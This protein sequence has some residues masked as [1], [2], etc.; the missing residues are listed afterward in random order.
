MTLQ[1]IKTAVEAGQTVCWASEIYRVVKDRLGQWL[2]VC[3]HN[4][5][6]IGLTWRDGVTMNGSPNEFFID[7]EAQL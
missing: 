1:E 6:T 3:G 5:Y 4:E 2:I 7:E